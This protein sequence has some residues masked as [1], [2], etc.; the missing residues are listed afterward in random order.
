MKAHPGALVEWARRV[1]GTDVAPSLTYVLGVVVGKARD[2][3]RV[4]D[5]LGRVHVVP[6]EV[7]AV[8]SAADVVKA[9]LER[10][11]R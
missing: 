7:P 3:W 9:A 1:G 4:L 5:A 6:W 10:R 2:G 8:L 11:R